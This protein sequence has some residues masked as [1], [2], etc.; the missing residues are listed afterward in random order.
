[1]K[2][3]ARELLTTI[4]VCVSILTVNTFAEDLVIDQN[5]IWS[6]G[7][8]AYDNVLITNGAVLTFQGSVTLNA[9]TLTIDPCCSLSANGTGYPESQGPGKGTSIASGY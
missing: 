4:I 6:T 8:Y 1:M 2:V 3:Q 5:T 9:Q 7:T